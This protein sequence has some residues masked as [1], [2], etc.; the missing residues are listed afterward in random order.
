MATHGSCLK[1]IVRIET[2]VFCDG[3]RAADDLGFTALLGA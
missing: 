1:W 3:C 2:I